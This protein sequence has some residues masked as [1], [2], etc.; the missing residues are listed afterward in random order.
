M[1]PLLVLLGLP[2]RAEVVVLHPYS[3]VHQTRKQKYT[4]P[5]T[6]LL[7]HWLNSPYLLKLIP[8]GFLNSYSRIIPNNLFRLL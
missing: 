7:L 5:A 3:V 8:M 1:L 2:M 4:D 6:G